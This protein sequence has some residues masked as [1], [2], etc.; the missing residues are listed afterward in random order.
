VEIVKEGTE[1]Q[2]KCPK[3]GSLLEYNSSD[4]TKKYNPPEGYDMEGH[5]SFHITCKKCKNT[6]FLSN[7]NAFTKREVDD[8]K[9]RS[10]Y[11]DD[12]Y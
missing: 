4:V 11:E 12:T 9:E 5:D 8:R 6:I 3:C 7:I 10:D 2:V 1:N